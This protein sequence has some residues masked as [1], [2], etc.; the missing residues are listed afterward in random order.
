MKKKILLRGLCS[1]VLVGALLFGVVSPAAMVPHASAAVKLTGKRKTIAFGKT[2][3]GK[4]GKLKVKG[5]KL[6]DKA[7]KA[8]QLKGVS[9]HGINWDVGEPFV[10]EKAL[11]NLRDEWGVNCFRVAMYTE[12]YNGYCV[13]DNASRKKLLNK[14]DVAVKAGKK[15]G[16]YVIIDWHILN[17][18]NPKKNQSKAKAFFK[19]VANK[20]RGEG[21]VLYEICNEPNGGTKWKTIKS[22]AKSVIKVIRKYNKNAIIIVGTPNWSQ[23]VDVASK[24]PITGYKNIMYSFHFYAATHKDSYRNKVKTALKNKL[25]LICTE[26]SACEASGNGSYD[27]S[28]AN[29]WMSLM[30]K[31][32]IGYCCWSL[33]NKPESASLL[34][35]S[36][37]RTSGFKTKDLSRMGRWLVEKYR[38]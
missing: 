16:M 5:T 13:T 35:S 26:F 17:D 2:F 27:F 9:S 10:N 1:L 38:K 6:V 4:H 3:Y 36:C 15:L 37:K 29:K 34:K 21:H 23:D 22:Y 8:V 31:N 32:K 25:P 33:S 24:S 19:K 28:S 20:Y 7:G 30:N 14:I 18:G 11:Q 12:D